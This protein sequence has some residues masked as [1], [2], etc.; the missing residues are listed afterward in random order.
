MRNS[1]RSHGRARRSRSKQSTHT[2]PTPCTS[3]ERRKVR[4]SPASRA[5]YGGGGCPPPSCLVSIDASAASGWAA[6]AAAAVPQGEPLRADRLLNGVRHCLV[7]GVVPLDQHVAVGNSVAD[8]PNRAKRARE[9]YHLCALSPS[10]R[11]PRRLLRRLRGRLPRRL[12]SRLCPLGARRGH[13]RRCRPLCLLH[14]ARRGGRAATLDRRD[15]RGRRDS[16]ASHCLCLRLRLLRLHLLLLRLLLVTL[17]RVGVPLRLRLA[18][19]LVDVDVLVVLLS[20]RVAHVVLARVAALLVVRRERDL[21]QQV[22]QAVLDRARARLVARRLVEARLADVPRGD[23][24]GARVHRWRVLAPGSADIAVVAAAVAR[25]ERVRVHRRQED[26]PALLLRGEHLARE[27]LLLRLLLRR[28]SS[29]FG[30][31]PARPAAQRRR[32]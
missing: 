24:L 5:H 1:E 17:H 4:P 26:L 9:R 27:H 8:R 15:S 6:A 2:G 22:G 13:R 21:V 19:E 16:G 29:P 20:D 32:F 12:R 30:G 23:A 3:A 25:L 7:G 14:S 10:V 18:E 11:Q 28:V 31:V